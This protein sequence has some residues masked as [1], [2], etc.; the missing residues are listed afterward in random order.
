MRVRILP[1]DRTLG[2]TPYAWLIYIV[3]FVLTP[4]YT[5]HSST[6]DW[7]LI[8]GA[9]AVF[10]VLYFRG[11]WARG[12]E[13]V[14]VAAMMTALGVALWPMSYAAG[15]FFVYAAGCI[16]TNATTRHAASGVIAIALLAVVEA[17]FLRYTIFNAAWPVVFTLLVG[18]INIHYAQVGRANARLRLAQ[19]EI[20][21]LAKVAERE[22]IARDL[23]DL[24]GH[25]L[26]LVILKSELAS[27]LAD[28][29][30]E[31][32][33]EEIRDVERI[34]RDALSQVRSAVA[35]YR[36]GGIDAELQHARAALGTA[37]VVLESNALS[38]PQLP[39]AHEAVLALALREAVTNI[40][41]H[42]GAR[43]CRITFDTRGDMLAMSIAD[44]GRG[45]SAPFGNG[46]TG[47][48]ERVELLGG[49]LTRD[50]RDGTTLTVKLPRNAGSC[51]SADIA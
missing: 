35:G 24:L 47:M 43:R 17:S 1:N 27:K 42:A 7:L 23:H 29:D 38:K 39:P 41:R 5:S 9:T 46:L 6:R 34:A 11:Y 40:V 48:R 28:R 26:S 13:L 19:D 21:H 25:T 50:G 16:G 44:D 49:T 36:S 33:R 8:L 31:R 18:A 45:G 37:G 20:E 3:P 14:L 22:R 12:R 4:F 10:T 51:A 30:T 2:W 15:A 32:A